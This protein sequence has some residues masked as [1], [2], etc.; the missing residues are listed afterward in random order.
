L[1]NLD[2]IDLSK[3]RAKSD[4]DTRDRDERLKLPMDHAQAIF[5]TAPFNNCASWDALGEPGMEGAQQIFRCAL[6]FVPILVYFTGSRREEL[7]GAMVDD[8][9]FDNGDIGR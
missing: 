4:R 8:V 2:K 6:Y 7:C 5:R 9:I 3:L 1:E